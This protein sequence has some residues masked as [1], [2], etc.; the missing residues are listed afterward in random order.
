LRGDLTVAEGLDKNEVVTF[1]ELL[2]SNTL[3]QE[4]LVNLLERKGII[5]RQELLEEIKKLRDKP[6]VIEV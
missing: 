5:T 6:P 2:M 4:A 3:E 1:Q